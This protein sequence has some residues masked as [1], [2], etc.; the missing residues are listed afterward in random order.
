MVLGSCHLASLVNRTTEELLHCPGNTATRRHGHYAV[1]QVS[2][3][4]LSLSTYIA[5]SARRGYKAAPCGS[6]QLRDLL[7]RP[8]L[9]LLHSPLL[10]TLVA[11]QH[12]LVDKLPGLQRR[13]ESSA[14]ASSCPLNLESWESMDADTPDLK[15]AM[16][17]GHTYYSGAM[18]MGHTS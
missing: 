13:W 12:V 16:Q 5:Y 1:W 14:G 17:V 18:H 6:A 11:L 7:A 15:V 3:Y 4:A 8:I 2:R 9:R 10:D